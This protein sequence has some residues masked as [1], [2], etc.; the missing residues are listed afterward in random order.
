MPTSYSRDLRRRAL[1]VRDEG[2]RLGVVAERFRI[3]RA[4]V[5]LWLKQRPGLRH[6]PLRPLEAAC[7]AGGARDAKHP[8]RHEP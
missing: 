2:E 3:G 7:R 8:R 1:E 4:S 5:S 6:H